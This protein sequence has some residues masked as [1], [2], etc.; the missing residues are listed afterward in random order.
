MT[1]PRFTIWLK[2]WFAACHINHISPSLS[3]SLSLMQLWCFNMKT[4]SVHSCWLIAARCQPGQKLHA[5]GHRLQAAACFFYYLVRLHATWPHKWSWQGRELSLNI[6]CVSQGL[7][8]RTVMAISCF[9][10]P[11]TLCVGNQSGVIPDLS[12]Q[13]RRGEPDGQTI[14][15]AVY[16]SKIIGALRC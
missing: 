12:Q 15:R 7:S 5:W 16:Y 3:L 14:I 1:H 9:T 13:L 4:Q 11:N 10:F 8:V 2:C 6:T